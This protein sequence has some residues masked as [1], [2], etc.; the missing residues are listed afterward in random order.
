MPPAPLLVLG[1]NGRLALALRH[2]L[3]ADTR[4]A[5]RTSSD[6]GCFAIGDYR[7]APPAVFDG[8]ETVINCA[9][10]TAGDTASMQRA[11]VEAPVHLATLARAAGVRRFVH[12][13]S[14][15]VLGHAPHIDARTPN[16]PVND[17]GRSK[18]AA[19]EQLLALATTGFAPVPVRFPAIVG[20]GARDKLRRLIK[21]WLRVRRIPVPRMPVERSMI[22]VDLAAQVL[23][24]VVNGTQRGVLHAADPRLFTYHEA[25]AAIAGATGRAV[26][27]ATLPDVTMAPL[28]RFAPGLFASLYAPSVLDP[29]ENV[30]ERLPSDLYQTIARMAQQ[31][32]PA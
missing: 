15:S 9:G 17:Y 22:S 30:A 23:A 19:E 3:P 10:I 4:Y 13:S 20:E 32:K 26:G 29:G 8:V 5:A 24:S 12:V 18:Q 1:G 6:A 27:V 16:A 2:Y 14:F 21:L 11:N 7:I 28:K 25:A 31:E